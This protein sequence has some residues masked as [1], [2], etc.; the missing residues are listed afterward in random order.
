MLPLIELQSRKVSVVDL[1]GC[2]V[3]ERLAMEADLRSRTVVVDRRESRR[4]S[5]V[6]ELAS[7]GQP[8]DPTWCCWRSKASSIGAMVVDRVM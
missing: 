8:T 3:H 5:H 1:R 4:R 2:D 7:I 6:R